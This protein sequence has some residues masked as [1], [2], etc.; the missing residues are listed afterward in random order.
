ME[1]YVIIGHIC[2]TDADY[3]T[4]GENAVQ[5]TLAGAREELKVIYEEIIAE[6]EENEL[7]IE[8]EDIEE[9]VICIG[10]NGNCIEKFKIEK[11]TIQQ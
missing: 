10:Y 4:L 6:C 8:F 5:T 1:V 3:V 9:D 2:N 11:R 7:T